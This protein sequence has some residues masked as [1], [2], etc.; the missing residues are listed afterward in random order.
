VNNAHLFGKVYFPR[1][2]MPVAA[3]VSNLVALVLQFIPLILFLIY[4][5][6]T[7]KLG[8][9]VRWTPALVFFPLVVLWTALSSFGVG[10][11]MA[12]GSARYR[13]LVHLNQ[14][15]VQVWMF[16][17]PVFYPLSM[18][19]PEWHAWIWLNPVAV[20]I[21][22]Y[23]WTLLGVGTFDGPLVVLSLLWTALILAG[24][25]VVFKRSER[26]VVDVL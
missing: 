3:V 21:E 16:A 15:L 10:L 1:L 5:V 2:V 6:V 18:I 25:L 23:R 8:D 12:A 26:M 9:S 19:G 13:D 11:W 20:N 7:G 17:T 24:G 4:F 22:L 14:Y